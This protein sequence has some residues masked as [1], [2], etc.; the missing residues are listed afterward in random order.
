MDDRCSFLTLDT[1]M[2]VVHQLNV[3][4][5]DKLTF[6]LFQLGAGIVVVKQL[7]DLLAHS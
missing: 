4:E 3:P 7:L 5:N 1:A 2:G 6:V